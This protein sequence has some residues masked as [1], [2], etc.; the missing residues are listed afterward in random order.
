[1]ETKK[2]DKVVICGLSQNSCAEVAY[3]YDNPEWEI[4]GL[5]QLYKVIPTIEK[6]AKRWFQLHYETVY[7]Q[8]QTDQTEWLAK[9]DGPVYMIKKHPDI[10]NSVEYPINEILRNEAFS[11]HYFTN[12]VCY[13]LALAWYE[14]VKKILLLGV[15]MNRDNELL[16][17]RRGVE[18][19]IGYLRGQGIQ[20]I[21]PKNCDLLKIAFLYGYENTEKIYQKVLN[22]VN[23]YN[24][25]IK[26]EMQ[27]L[28]QNRDAMHQFIGG[29][30]EIKE[31]DPE[32]T[33]K[34][35]QY[36]SKIQELDNKVRMGR[37]AINQYKGIIQGIKYM[38][39]TW[40]EYKIEGA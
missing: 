19:L 15:D 18:Y 20:V 23:L 22:Q 26:R 12:I 8:F 31:Y 28:E 36:G 24:N 34:I 39:K 10:P 30:E 1:M 9:F 38:E 17:Q 29:I 14:G 40:G 33:E 27:S 35:Q 32:N 5:N 11:E 16:A 25:I 6:Q 21:L 7:S 4:W 2:A 3:Y 37:Q 13:M